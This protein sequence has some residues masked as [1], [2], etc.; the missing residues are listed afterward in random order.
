VIEAGCAGQPG[1]NKLTLAVL[2]SYKMS[3]PFQHPLKPNFSAQIVHTIARNMPGSQSSTYDPVPPYDMDDLESSAPPL[4]SDQ[5]S[6]DT[7]ATERVNS[8]Y[9]Q[10]INYRY[11]RQEEGGQPETM[12]QRRLKFVCTHCNRNYEGLTERDKCNYALAFLIFT[13]A[14]LTICISIIV[15]TVRG[16]QCQA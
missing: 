13:L 6:E 10:N 1:S 12:E 8:E 5:R 9:E 11:P 16:K 14:A 3:S 4:S 2:Q 15:S 7:D